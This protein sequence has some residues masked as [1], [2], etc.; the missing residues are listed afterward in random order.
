MAKTD[1]VKVTKKTTKKTKKT[2]T[3]KDLSLWVYN[4]NNEIEKFIVPLELR[5]DYI[6]R[7]GTLE[8]TTKYLLENW[9][10]CVDIHTRYKNE[11]DKNG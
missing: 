8:I 5:M 7:F 4:E 11:C 3:I 10:K 2:K 9:L 1:K 6:A